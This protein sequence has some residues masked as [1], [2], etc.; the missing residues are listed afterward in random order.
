MLLFAR[1]AGKHD[2]T[3]HHAARERHTMHALNRPLAQDP[4]DGHAPTDRAV[5]KEHLYQLREK[6][7]E[8]LVQVC[9]HADVFARSLSHL[10]ACPR[11][12]KSVPSGLTG[13]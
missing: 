2:F 3:F 8:K 1:L 10:L 12:C 4:T 11:V 6:L 5:A 7:R 9:Y 13:R